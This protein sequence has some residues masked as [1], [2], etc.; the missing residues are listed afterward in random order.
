MTIK[1]YTI[2]LTEKELS[3]LGELVVDSEIFQRDETLTEQGMND[4]GVKTIKSL[5]K[6]LG[7][8]LEQFI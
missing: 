6:K 1:K 8:N 7:L 2:T 3:L 5:S 4:D